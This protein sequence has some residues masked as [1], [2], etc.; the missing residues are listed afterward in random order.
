MVQAF[1]KTAGPFSIAVTGSVLAAAY[2]SHL[3]LSGLTPRA[4]AAAGRSVSG[5]LDV[6][7]QI[8]STSFAHAVRSAFVHGMN[9]SL[10][11]STAIAIAGL[12]LTVALLPG[13]PRSYV[14]TRNPLR[15][16][17]G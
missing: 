8:G 17:I 7:V 15:Q 5:G 1:Q 13:G 4:A 9:V 3:D 6:A 2:T 12:I 16:R 11:V 14:P 10:L